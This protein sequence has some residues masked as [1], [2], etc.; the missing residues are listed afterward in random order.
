MKAH[1]EKDS[2]KGGGGILESANKE[3]RQ[4]DVGALKQ[5]YEKSTE[6]Q[7]QRQNLDAV[8]I[9][10]YEKRSGVGEFSVILESGLAVHECYT[11]VLKARGAMVEIARKAM[12]FEK[13]RAG[14]RPPPV[15]LASIPQ[16][17]AFLDSI[18]IPTLEGMTYRIYIDSLPKS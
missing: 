5:R 6:W 14:N 2:T 13:A 15:L 10:R 3:C 9:V 18:Q 1:N 17:A 16:N 8:Y 4:K 7:K 12:A 11:S